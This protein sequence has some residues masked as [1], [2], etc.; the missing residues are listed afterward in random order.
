MWQTHWSCQH[1]FIQMLVHRVRSAS[2]MKP[3]ALRQPFALHISGTGEQFAVKVINVQR[4]KMLG[5][6]EYDNVMVK[7]QREIDILQQLSNPRS[8]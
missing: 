2:V 3:D 7:L 6:A 5:D 8:A 1:C 4:L